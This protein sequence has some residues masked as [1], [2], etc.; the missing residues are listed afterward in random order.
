MNKDRDIEVPR[1]AAFGQR[2][3]EPEIWNGGPGTGDEIDIIGPSLGRST[4]AKAAPQID[5]S[6][7]RGRILMF[8]ESRG[9]GFIHSETESKLFVHLSECGGVKSLKRG[10]RVAY[11]VGEDRNGKRCAVNVDVIGV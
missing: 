5:P 1:L 8:N 7:L 2:K 11:E 9:F 10:Q 3:Y 6:K 4:Y